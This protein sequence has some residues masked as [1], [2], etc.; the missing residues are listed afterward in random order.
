[1]PHSGGPQPR[2]A[3][4]LG[5]I[6]LGDAQEVMRVFLPRPGKAQIPGIFI[7]PPDTLQPFAF[8]ILLAD[9]LHH[10]A[11]AY[12]HKFGLDEDQVRYTISE[13]LAAELARPTEE[14]KRASGGEPA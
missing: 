7:D 1:M 9:L 14:M 13:G 10:G 8:G 6:K 12:A 2:G 3:I 4:D 5:G 11:K